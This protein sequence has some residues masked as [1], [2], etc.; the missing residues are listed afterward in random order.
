M[1]REDDDELMWLEEEEVEQQASGTA[2][3]VEVKKDVEVDG[4]AEDLIRSLEAELTRSKKELSDVRK[5]L[6][7]KVMCSLL[8]ML[9]CLHPSGA[10]V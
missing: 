9:C 5:E 10:E 1:A 8:L 7:A 2:A 3:E 6:A 4:A